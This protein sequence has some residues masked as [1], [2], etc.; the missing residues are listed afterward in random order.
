MLLL[1]LIEK[2]SGYM[3]KKVI[4]IGASGHGKVIADIVQA[5][6]DE[7]LGF[8]DDDIKKK[9]LGVVSDHVKYDAEF[10]IGIG[11]SEIRE[12]ISQLNCKWYTAVHPAAVISPN[13]VI[14]EGTVVMANAVVNSGAVNRKALYYKYKLCS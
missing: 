10:I 14:G 2:G 4:I 5:N 13:A 7:V 9:T 6:G 8:L 11:S 1:Y 3:N 12:R